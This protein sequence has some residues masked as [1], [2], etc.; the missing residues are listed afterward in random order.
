[1][2]R[3]MDETEICKLLNS[4]LRDSTWACNSA[5]ESLGAGCPL[6]A[7]AAATKCKDRKGGRRRRRRRRRRKRLGVLVHVT[8][9]G[10]YGRVVSYINY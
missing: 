8:T 3:G 6:D 1:M 2:S 9:C 5:T 10:D 7:A 4:A